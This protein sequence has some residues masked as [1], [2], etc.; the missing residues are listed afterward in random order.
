MIWVFAIRNEPRVRI[1]GNQ[2]TQRQ[3]ATVSL[4]YSR[5]FLSIFHDQ[6]SAP[7]VSNK[8]GDVGC[9]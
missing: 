5:R 2:K 1:S 3:K 6:A 8:W 9:V 4:I 7:G